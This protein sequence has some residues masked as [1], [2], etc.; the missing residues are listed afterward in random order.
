MQDDDKGRVA[1]AQLVRDMRDNIA[2]HIEI[3]QLQARITRAKYVALVKEGFT[4]AQ[5][6]QLCK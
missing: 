2:A 4:E 5:A 3:N 6:L 1:L